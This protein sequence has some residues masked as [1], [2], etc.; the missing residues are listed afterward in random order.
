MVQRQAE[1]ELFL[2][3]LERIRIG[4]RGPAPN[5]FWNAHVFGE[6]IETCDLHRWAIGFKSA[7]PYSTVF[8]T[9]CLKF[10]APALV[11]SNEEM[12]ALG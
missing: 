9:R 3:L 5:R 4:R 1:I 10:V 2:R 6:L 12:A 11:L 7:A 8:R